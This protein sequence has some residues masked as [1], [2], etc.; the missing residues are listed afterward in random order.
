MVMVVKGSTRSQKSDRY[1]VT[2]IVYV[3]PHRTS[4]CGGEAYRKW[5]PSHDDIGRIR[6]QAQLRQM[7]CRYSA[8]SAMVYRSYLL[9]DDSS[10]ELIVD[11]LGAS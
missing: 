4:C 3:A 2:C 5:L 8:M 7:A 6:G 11:L 10:E 1:N 9:V